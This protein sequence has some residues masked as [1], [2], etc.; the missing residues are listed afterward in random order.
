MGGLRVERVLRC[1]PVVGRGLSTIRLLG[2]RFVR[3][4]RLLCAYL[5]RSSGQPQEV[6]AAQ[7][8]GSALY[9]GLG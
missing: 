8:A 2:G 3:T 7:L 9:L 1:G 4:G 6:R 5:G